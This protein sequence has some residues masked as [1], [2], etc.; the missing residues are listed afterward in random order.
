MPVPIL[1]IEII[2]IIDIETLHTIDIESI[3]TIGIETIQTIKTLDIKIIDHA[4]ILIT[5]QY[6]TIIKIDHAITHRT[7]NQVI[8]IHEETTLGH[9]IGITHVIKTHNK[10]IVVHL[11]IKDK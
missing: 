2:E 3:S 9:H 8:T 7:E 1:E 11:N 6:I 10:N 5:D 4:T